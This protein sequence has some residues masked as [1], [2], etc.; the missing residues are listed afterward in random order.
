[1][2]FRHNGKTVVTRV[3]DRGPYVAGRIFD[4]T[5]GACVVIDHCFTGPIYYRIG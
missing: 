1:V 4:L 2:T 3:I 5:H